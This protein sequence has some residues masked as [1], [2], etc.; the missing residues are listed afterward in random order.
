MLQREGKPRSGRQKWMAILAR[1]NLDDLAAIVERHGG[2]P[3]HVMLKPAEVGTIMIEG[4]AGG[5][6]VRFNAGEATV[7]RCAVRLETGT[8][9]FSY[10]LGSDKRKALLAAV[11]D[12]GLQDVTRN[13]GLLKE[14]SALADK[15]V[16][17]R[18]L[19]SR[20]AAATK[21]EFFTMVRGSE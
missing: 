8:L 15:Q 16:A 9:G 3:P 11:L 12:A 19:A 6:G 1:A 5:T 10:A 14:V 17:V 13:E 2:L 20:K 4:R 18:D 7:T 21:V